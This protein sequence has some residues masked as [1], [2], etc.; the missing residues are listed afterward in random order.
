MGRGGKIWSD[1]ANLTGLGIVTDDTVGIKDQLKIRIVLKNLKTTNRK[2]SKN[3]QALEKGRV[4]FVS[5]KAKIP[6]SALE[7]IELTSVADIQKSAKAIYNLFKVKNKDKDRKDLGVPRPI[8]ASLVNQIVI[9]ETPAIYAASANRDDHNL[10]HRDALHPLSNL[11]VRPKSAPLTKLDDFLQRPRMIIQHKEESHNDVMMNELIRPKS[12]TA[13]RILSTVGNGHVEKVR[14]RRGSVLED[15]DIMKVRDRKMLLQKE[16]ERQILHNINK[17]FHL[18]LEANA[19]WQRQKSWMA[20]VQV[21]KF[22]NPMFPM[23]HQ[24][25]LQLVLKIKYRKQTKS[26]GIIQRWWL[27]I[28]IRQKFKRDMKLLFFLRFFTIR[29]NAILKIRHR[30]Q[31]LL[32]IRQFITDSSS[33]AKRV[34]AIYNFRKNCMTVQRW[35]RAWFQIKQDR[36]RSLWKAMERILKRRHDAAVKQARINEINALKAISAMEGFDKTLDQLNLMN[37]KINQL[38]QKEERI[39]KSVIRSQRQEDRIRTELLRPKEIK[40]ETIVAENVSAKKDRKT[41]RVERKTKGKSWYQRKMEDKDAC[42]RMTILLEILK[43]QRRRHIRKEE[44]NLRRSKKMKLIYDLNE[45]KE[46][47]LSET[48]SAPVAQKVES[49]KRKPFL[50]LTQGGIDQLDGISDFDLIHSRG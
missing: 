5:K 36:I 1:Q 7:K 28:K 46:F 4:S 17:K 49:S 11:S 3:R 27:K 18:D 24:R 40:K 26:I 30:R 25:R 42:A 34:L 41:E 38:V 50:L 47:L 32:L 6:Y 8:F 16:R 2:G 14:Q 21:L 33:G 39:M 35:F 20:I 45:V 31:G 37:K 48:P 22:M 23:I 9:E 12:A 29:T 19:L 44:V 15:V 43:E 13:L 10:G